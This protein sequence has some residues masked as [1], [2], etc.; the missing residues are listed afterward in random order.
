MRRDEPAWADSWRWIECC[1]FA[2]SLRVDSARLAAGHK[3]RPL[4]ALFQLEVAAN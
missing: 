3:W 2:A 4:D 1:S